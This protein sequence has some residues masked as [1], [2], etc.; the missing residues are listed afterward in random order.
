M[1][2]CVCPHLYV[3]VSVSV[4]VCV[5]LCVDYVCMCMCMYIGGNMHM[6]RHHGGVRVLRMPRD[7]RYLRNFVN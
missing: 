4:H 1:P 2:V 5:C 6:A 7:S 3:Y